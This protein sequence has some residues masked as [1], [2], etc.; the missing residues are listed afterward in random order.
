MRAE[1]RALIVSYP[2]AHGSSFAKHATQSN[3]FK[4]LGRRF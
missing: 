2:P 1:G 4:V 3:L